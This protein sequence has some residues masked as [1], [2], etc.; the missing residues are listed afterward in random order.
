[1]GCLWWNCQKR[2]QTFPVTINSQERTI[3]NWWADCAAGSHWPRFTFWELSGYSDTCSWRR[4]RWTAG[5]WALAGH[6]RGW[7]P[8]RFPLAAASGSSEFG[9]SVLYPFPL[10]FLLSIHSQS[11]WKKITLTFAHPPSPAV[12]YCFLAESS[13]QKTTKKKNSGWFLPHGLKL[14]ITAWHM[15]HCHQANT[16]TLDAEGIRKCV[17][18]AGERMAEFWVTVSPRTSHGLNAFSVVSILLLGW[19]LIKHM[20]KRRH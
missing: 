4:L 1:M 3:G 17:S 16:S 10:F 12:S 18:W 8:F 11:T 7:V 5:V 14:Y 15:W 2:V 6:Y 9:I 19:R 13:W 20:V